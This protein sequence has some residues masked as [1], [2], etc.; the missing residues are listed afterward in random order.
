M[1][2]IYGNAISIGYATSGATTGGIY[3]IWL[4]IPSIASSVTFTAVKGDV[5][6]D[7]KYISSIGAAKIT[8][9]TEDY[10]GEWSI[11]GTVGG[12]TA[13]KAVTIKS[14]TVDYFVDFRNDFIPLVGD[15][16]VGNLVTFDN[17]EW[18]VVHQEG[19]RYY[20]GL[21]SLVGSETFGNNSIYAGSNLAVKAK[22]Y[23]TDTMSATAL[24]Y[25]VDTTVE[26][27]TGKVFAATYDQMNGGF[28]YFTTNE[29]RVCTL[30]GTAT[31][32][33]TSS[34]HPSNTSSVA[35]VD[36][37]GNISYQG[38]SSF[39][40]SFRPFICIKYY[41]IGFDFIYTGTCNIRTD[42]VIEFL[43]SGDFTPTESQNIDAFLVGGGSSGCGG[44]NASS[45]KYAG[46]GGSGGYTLT[47]KNISITA[48][49]SYNIQIGAGGVAT[50]ST[51]ALVTSVIRPGGD[52]TAFGFTASGGK[53]NSSTATSTTANRITGGDGGCGG[54]SGSGSTTDS[55]GIGGSNGNNGGGSS[56]GKGQGTSTCEFGE[57]TGKLYAGGG[58]GGQYSSS[59]VNKG[60]EGGGGD[61][62]NSGAAATAG[63]P[64]TGGGGGGGSVS[65]NF[66]GASGG[67]GI[68]CIR[69]HQE[70]I[71]RNIPDFNFTGKYNIR[72]DDVIEILDSGNII[73]NKEENIDIFLVG[74]GAS[75]A[76]NS[77]I[78]YSAGGGGAGGITKTLI[79]TKVS[80]EYQLIIGEGGVVGVNY[81]AGG[82]TAFGTLVTAKGGTSYSNN[83]Y[84]NGGT[85]GSGGGAA[86]YG[87]NDLTLGVGGSDG[88]NGVDGYASG[89]TTTSHKGGTGQGTTTREFG[90]S[91]GKLYAAGGAG[92]R[93]Y[94]T[95]AVVSIGGEGG[96]GNG[97][98][99][100]E[101]NSSFIQ[102]TAGKDNTG[103]G[104]GG[105]ATAKSSKAAAVNAHAANGG[106]GI[107]CIRKTKN[108]TSDLPLTG[109]LALGNTVTFDNK[110][111]IVVHN[112]DTKYF[113]A[114]SVIIE[115]CNSTVLSTK[116]TEYLSNFS[117]TAQNY[118]IEQT[119]DS[120]TGKVFLPSKAQL[121]SGFTYYKNNANR[122]CR[123]NG[124]ASYWWGMTSSSSGYNDAV[125]NNGAISSN[126]YSA[127]LGFRP[128]ICIDTSLSGSDTKE[129]T[130]NGTYL[131]NTTLTTPPGTSY[132]ETVQYK[133]HNGTGGTYNYITFNSNSGALGMNYH[134]NSMD[135]YTSVYNF[136]T[137]KWLDDIYR[138]II[139]DNQTVTEEF[140]DWFIANAAI[141]S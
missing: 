85:G 25:C 120:Y 10:E 137:Q 8:L 128:H 109:D 4:T 31:T 56:G 107:I 86:V 73:F 5:S 68:V 3:S 98:W 99:S 2:I 93:V 111:W 119:I 97:A 55:N 92:G 126:H 70:S 61:G 66:N 7:S 42:G 135:S 45:V 95:S 89:S 24:E 16:I 41:P 11:G 51:S 103:S 115:N 29:S 96:G 105:Y 83:N 50:E 32:Y 46:G 27:V 49:T 52:T 132:T 117:S 82:E 118:M 91:S 40:N 33:W 65:T 122:I 21:N 44:N 125:D 141:K 12:K 102:A 121:N 81:G 35:N 69:L 114:S 116:C 129:T 9:P 108:P 23:E 64:N 15:L 139:F 67:S 79:N 57:S 34:K 14:G 53:G 76:E 39:A 123:Y 110:S 104:G 13:V 127:T 72:D 28:S 18:R 106:S 100:N 90:E 38:P 59:P 87:K 94:G 20:L 74:G 84:T 130:L 124:E 6:V 1:A 43:T 63:T 113:L 78:T 58:G 112:D 138:T 133:Y 131:F 60:G 22:S 62:A 136:S 17:K 134:Y 19:T 48:N 36:S 77:D 75:G 101:G 71:K 47:R 30:N 140:Y 88:S 37:A 54:G 26:E 80:G